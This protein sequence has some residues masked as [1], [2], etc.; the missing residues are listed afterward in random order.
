MSAR[1]TVSA[2]PFVAV[3]VILNG[4]FIGGGFLLPDTW[5][6]V[7]ERHLAVDNAALEATLGDMAFWKTWVEAMGGEDVT[8]DGDRVTWGDVTLGVVRQERGGV[9][10]TMTG[11]GEVVEGQLDVAP[12]PAGAAVTWR[13]QGTVGWSPFARWAAF[14]G[15]T[16]TSDAARF[17]RS[18][19]A[20][21]R[22]LNDDG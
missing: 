18:W 11:L 1:R 14:L 15:A 2:A 17:R 12:S 9:T 20:L 22:A 4:G 13:E 6:A 10:Y 21:E 8:V 16:K 3:L 19:D 7:D 5:Q